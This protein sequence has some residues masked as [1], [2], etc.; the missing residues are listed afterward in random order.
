MDQETRD[1]L[2]TYYL[3]NKKY[4]EFCR[5]AEQEI[6]TDPLNVYLYSD[7]GDQYL[8]LGKLEKAEQTYSKMEKLFPSSPEAIQRLAEIFYLQG[9]TEKSFSQ[10]EKLIKKFPD[11]EEFAL[12]W[13]DQL[14]KYRKKELQ[15]Y[16]EKYV[17]QFPKRSSFAIDLAAFYQK[18]GKTDQA[19]Q[20]LENYCRQA[21]EEAEITK[22]LADLY[23]DSNQLEKSLEFLRKYHEKTGGDYHSHHVLGDVLVAMGQRT[24]G[25]EE[26]RKALHL[27]QTSF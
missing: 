6:H 25:R 22:Q 26:Y 27:L 20:L 13:V 18:K 8:Q 9:E 2:V 14:T 21:G 12:T 5:L 1:K 4:D 3:L 23:F 10:Y 7:L 19:I 15:T 17:K 11:N 16:L 24:A